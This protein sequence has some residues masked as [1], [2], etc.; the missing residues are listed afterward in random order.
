MHCVREEVAHLRPAPLLPMN[1]VQIPAVALSR[2][3]TLGHLLLEIRSVTDRGHTL[4][5]CGILENRRLV[6]QA[7]RQRLKLL[8]GQLGHIQ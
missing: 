3:L 7:L 8:V 1:V 5:L 4:L 2:Q 6:T